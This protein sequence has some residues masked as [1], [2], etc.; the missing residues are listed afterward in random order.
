MKEQS[1][2][3]SINGQQAVDAARKFCN[4]FC[5]RSVEGLGQ[6][7]IVL[8][9]TD[10]YNGYIQKWVDVAYVEEENIPELLRTLSAMGFYG[11]F[12]IISL[13]T[14]EGCMAYDKEL[15]CLEIGE[16]TYTYIV[17]EYEKEANEYCISVG[18]STAWIQKFRVYAYH[19]QEA[20]DLVAD[21][22][23]EQEMHG[24]YADYYEITDLCDGE[25]VENYAEANNLLCCGNHGIYIQIIDIKR[26]D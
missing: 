12:A 4:G 16:D 19:T 8:D 14:Y 23:E 10:K 24:L 17:N 22:I 11:C 25:T 13:T 7:E 6:M 2:T 1:Y 18:T 26:C 9:S 21:Y 3:I 15:Y 5:Y 20:A